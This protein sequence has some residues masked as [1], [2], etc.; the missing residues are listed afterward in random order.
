M[1][2]TFP[3]SVKKTVI[4]LRKQGLTY[5]QIAKKVDASEPTVANWIRA[6]ALRGPRVAKSL[7]SRTKTRL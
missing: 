5:K 3:A 1:S 2:M 7:W 4:K 6:E